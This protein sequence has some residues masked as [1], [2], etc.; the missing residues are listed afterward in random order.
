M[1]ERKKKKKT[2]QALAKQWQFILSIFKLL[3]VKNAKTQPSLGL[4]LIFVGKTGGD[5]T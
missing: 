4:G 1:P 3:S 2:L 5:S